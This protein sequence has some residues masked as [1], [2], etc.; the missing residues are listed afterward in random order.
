MHHLA[1]HLQ[2]TGIATLVYDHRCFGASAGQ[3]RF[4]ANPHQQI[5]DIHDAVCFLTSSAAVL[6][7]DTTRLGIWGYSYSG[8]H[9]IVAAAL[10][11]R[12]RAVAVLCPMVSGPAM[13]QRKVAP[14]LQPA[15]MAAV[16]ED[17]AARISGAAPAYMPIMG[18]PESVLP[19]E[20]AK[21]F[22]ESMQSAAPDWQ[23]RCSLQST[24]WCKA[25]DPQVYIEA[26]APTPLLM[27]VAEDD[28]DAPTDTQL[29]AFAMARMP[30]DLHVFPG[31]HFAAFEDGF[32][33]ELA[34]RIAEFYWSRFGG[35]A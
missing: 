24:L 5:S 10:D 9:G 4:E 25:Y 22:F 13:I 3:P 27:L 32:R 17:R 11:K 31:G 7:I 21:V 30:K 8:G 1:A 18:G 16:W 23:N 2:S 12:I 28:V 15:M 35:R 29:A 33:P 34:G 26:V 6:G 14:H 20:D 19:S